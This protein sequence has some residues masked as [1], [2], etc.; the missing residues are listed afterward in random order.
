[1]VWPGRA[2][3]G[4]ARSFQLSNVFPHLTVLENVRLAAQAQGKDSFQLLRPFTAYRR[5]L[6]DFGAFPTL[7]YPGALEIALEPSDRQGRPS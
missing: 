7:G 3:A 5:Y 2:K 1:M 6:T 4:M